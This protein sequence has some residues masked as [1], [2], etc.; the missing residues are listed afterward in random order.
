MCYININHSLQPRHQ[1][2]SNIHKFRSNV[3]TSISKLFE[4][5]DKCS[6]FFFF[7]NQNENPKSY[8]HTC[9]VYIILFIYRIW[10]LKYIG[11]TSSKYIYMH[12]CIQTAYSIR[13]T[14]K[15]IIIYTKIKIIKMKTR[16]S[17]KLNKSKL[18]KRNDEEEVFILLFLYQTD[19]FK[20]TR[21]TTMTI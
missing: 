4:F 20:G 12:M 18:H 9:A 16:R 8:V 1:E 11:F 10:I 17:M 15:S 13:S 6:R 21:K 19:Y 2:F 3:N 14:P 5:R 7:Q